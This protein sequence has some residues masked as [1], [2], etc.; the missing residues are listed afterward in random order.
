M[1]K[2][3]EAA[4]AAAS[5]TESAEL[6]FIRLEIDELSESDALKCVKELVDL[7]GKTFN[8]YIH[9]CFHNEK[10]VQPCKISFLQTYPMKTK[11]LEM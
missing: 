2:Y 8:I 4:E 6:D 5:P 10:P 3:V 7:T 9:E 11:I 1:K